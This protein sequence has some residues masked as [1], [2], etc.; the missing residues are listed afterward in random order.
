MR[1]LVLVGVGLASVTATLSA[2]RSD[3][4]ELGVYGN[5]TRFD[6]GYQLPNRVG[7]GLR[8]GYFLSDRVSIEVDGTYLGPSTVAGRA[9]YF[10][11]TGHASL[12]YN[13]PLGPS[14]FYILGGA[15]R[16]DLGTTAP[17]NFAENG[18]HGGA[19]LRFLIGNRLGL[20]VDGKAFYR[21]PKSL[22]TGEQAVHVFGSAGITYVTGRPRRGGYYA[23]SGDRNHQ[24]YWGGQG[25]LFI[26]KTNVQS[27]TA[28]PIFG[29]HWLITSR[30]TALYVGIEQSFFL[31][32]AHAVI[33]DPNS[34][35][36]SV[37]PAFRDVT[38]SE[39]RRVMFGLVTHPAQRRMEPF[40]GGG[41][42][43]VQILSPFVD[44]QGCNLSQ[45]AEAE[46]RVA[47][48]ASK[49]F[50]WVKGGLQINYSSKLNVFANYLITSSSRGFL[51]DGNTHTLQGGIRYSL[52]TSKEGISE[53]N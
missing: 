23:R 21:P 38:F 15:S 22:L 53:R 17:Y 1:A 39:V 19:G 32:D 4:I 5:F 52:G 26:Y 42:A 48:A 43:M 28:E 46:D 37:G 34:S 24:W 13:F 25:G 20:R 29:G 16:I 7:G 18:I 45:A 30:R 8:F 40:V 31:S 49:A 6:P 2:Q 33:F 14:S 27:S 10:L 41:F 11:H 51:L 35:S 50:F 47:E 12:V 3:Q 44:C 9:S 36:S